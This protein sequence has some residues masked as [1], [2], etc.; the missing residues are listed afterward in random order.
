MT[1]LNLIPYSIKKKRRNKLIYIQYI[2]LGIVILCILFFGVYFPMGKLSKLKTEVASLKKQA[3]S[4]QGII[5]EGQ[6]FRN[7]INNL[8]K[9]IN[10]V[11]E[12][13]TNKVIVSDKI[14]GLQAFI[15]QD[16]I[17][18]NLNYSG[19]IVSINGEAL[20]YNSISEFAANLQMSQNYSGARISNINYNKMNNSYNF[21]L[22][23]K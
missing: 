17:F 19:N 7:Q 8:D 18:N 15:P 4:S 6:N 11:N 9:F 5:E 22:I 10:K 13:T 3:Y 14:R 20:K 21:S 16:I 1:E 12:L 2:S 23:I